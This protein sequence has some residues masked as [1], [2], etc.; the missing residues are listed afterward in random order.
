MPIPATIE[1]LTSE[2]FAILEGSHVIQLTG[3]IRQQ[4]SQ[5]GMS[6]LDQ[7]KLST[8]ASELARNILVH[9]GEGK[10][11]LECIRSN[12][13]IGIRLLFSDRGPGIANVEQAMQPGFS[14]GIGMGLGLSGAKQLADEFHLT[15]V[16]GE[17]TTVTI[18]K[19]VND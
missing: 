15:S 6:L 12:S 1:V 17:G 13:K 14:T 9:G 18:L 10:A 4:A 11:Q 19:W 7:T 16:V 8:A 2:T 3:Q 5:M